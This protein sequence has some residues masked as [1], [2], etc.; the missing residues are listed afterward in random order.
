MCINLPERA[1]WSATWRDT[2]RDRFPMALLRLRSAFGLY[3]KHDFN[4]HSHKSS[5]HNLSQPSSDSPVCSDKWCG[6]VGEPVASLDLGFRVAVFEVVSWVWGDKQCMWRCSCFRF[7]GSL[8]YGRM[9]T[10]HPI[11]LENHKQLWSTTNPS[12]PMASRP[13]PFLHRRSAYNL[14]FWPGKGKDVW[15]PLLH[16]DKA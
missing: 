14:V 8:F 4:W 16:A 9:Y 1:T 12:R 11:S 6:V 10:D 3:C 13:G 7:H 2:W 15:G 5:K